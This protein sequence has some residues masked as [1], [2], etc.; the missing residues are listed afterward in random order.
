MAMNGKQAV[1][2]GGATGIGSGIVRALVARGAK[3]HLC[4]IDM[5]GAE[6]LAA[7]LPAGT[8]A[9]H[10]VNVTD[11]ASL[12]AAEAAARAGGAIDFVF[13]NAGAIVVKPLLDT[14]IAEWKWL[15]DI[16]IFGTVMAIQAFLPGLLA[17]DSR[18]RLIIT[19][20]S[21][22]IN[23]SPFPGLTAYAASK[24]AQLGLCAGL[25]PELEGTNVDLSVIFPGPVSSSIVA[26]SEVAR[27]GSIRFTG[28][29]RGEPG[30]ILPPLAGERIVAAVERGQRYIATHPSKATRGHETRALQD[31]I[32]EQ[33]FED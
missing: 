25:F 27:S 28:E 26:K 14:T 13:V 19:S 12:A 16:N 15:F 23:A 24:S 6:A 33:F 9:L 22:A 11:P 3:V 4:D 8:V 20:S 1:V 29:A 18:S 21:A 17:Q 2:I 10:Q 32:M 7:D 30:A 31:E 5:A